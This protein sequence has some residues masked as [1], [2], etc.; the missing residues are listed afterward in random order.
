MLEVFTKQFMEVGL[1]FLRDG[2]YAS[3]WAVSVLFAV[4]F[5]VTSAE[6]LLEQ[7][8]GGG[9]FE[10][11]QPAQV[12]FDE[13]VELVTVMVLVSKQAKQQEYILIHN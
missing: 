1:T 5:N 6:K 13:F 8:I 10:C 11:D 4:G 12:V 7:I 3:R 2:V 9:F